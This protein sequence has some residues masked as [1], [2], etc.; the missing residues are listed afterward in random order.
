MKAT[1]AMTTTTTTIEEAE[2]ETGA[3]TVRIAAH[4]GALVRVD[5]ESRAERERQLARRFPG[6]R[7]VDAKDPAGAVSAFRRWLDGDLDAL[8]SLPCDAGGTEFQRAVWKALRSIPAGETVSYGEIARR[9]GRPKASRAVGAA[10]GSNPIAIVVPCHRVIASDDTLCGYGGGLPRKR[11][12]LEHEA[13]H[14]RR[15]LFARPPG[16]RRAL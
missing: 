14:A 1:T 12:L 3:G 13:K 9:I 6:A 5:F 2:I 15:G 4:D 8:D 7:F 10:N 16:A 11:W